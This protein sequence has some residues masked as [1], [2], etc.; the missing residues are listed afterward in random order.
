MRVILFVICV[1]LLRGSY[2]LYR[3]MHH[4]P[5][6]TEQESNDGRHHT[7]ITTAAEAQ[8]KVNTTMYAATS[9]IYTLQWLKV[10]KD[11]IHIIN[12]VLLYGLAHEEKRAE[13]TQRRLSRMRKEALLHIINEIKV[14]ESI[15][16]ELQQLLH[17]IAHSRKKLAHTFEQL[18]TALM[19]MDHENAEALLAHHRLVMASIHA[20]ET[21]LE[22]TCTL[23]N[24]QKWPASD[25]MHE[26]L[27]TINSTDRRKVMAL[28]QL[29]KDVHD[30]FYAAYHKTYRKKM[31]VG[32]FLEILLLIYC[33]DQL[34]H[35]QKSALKRHLAGLIPLS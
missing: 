26:M 31:R 18:S 11:D 14:Q 32:E 20:R 28:S 9:A 13:Q 8:A 10:A 35:G 17:S 5:I 4:L 7:L 2:G 22:N 23:I 12:D 19:D 29:R 34:S 33:D 15:E 1:Y 24:K 30:A 27:K 16:H 6:N 25:V 21:S 3:I